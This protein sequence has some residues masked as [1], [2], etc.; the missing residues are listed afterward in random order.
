MEQSTDGGMWLTPNKSQ[1]EKKETGAG[2]HGGVVERVIDES[3]LKLGGWKEYDKYGTDELI[4]F[5]DKSFRI[6]FK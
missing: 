4:F 5:C 3:K 2:Q 1:I 6:F